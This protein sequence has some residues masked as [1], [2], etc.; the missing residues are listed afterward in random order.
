MWNIRKVSGKRKQ[1]ADVTSQ[2]KKKIKLY[3]VHIASISPN[4]WCCSLHRSVSSVCPVVPLFIT[5]YLWPFPNALIRL[6]GS[7]VFGYPVSCSLS[8][9]LSIIYCPFPGAALPSFTSHACLSVQR[10][11]CFPSLLPHFRVSNPALATSASWLTK[12]H[13]QGHSVRQWGCQFSNIIH[14]IRTH[15]FCSSASSSNQCLLS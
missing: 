13:M 9:L 14:W 12:L 3:H 7:T 11:F 2:I 15:W 1:N 6:P 5:L 8:S 10:Y 4:P